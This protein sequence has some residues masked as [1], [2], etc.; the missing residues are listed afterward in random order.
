MRGGG[1]QLQ[2]AELGEGGVFSFGLVFILVY[3]EVQIDLPLG[4]AAGLGLMWA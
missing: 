2:G 1:L 4:A 3:V